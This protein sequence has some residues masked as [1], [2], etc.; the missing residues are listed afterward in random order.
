[1]N[2]KELRNSSSFAHGRMD[3]LETRINY[4]FANPLL[5]A[6][7]LTHPS[8]AYETQGPHFD[9]Q[10]LEFLGDA[11]L[12]LI[13]TRELFLAFPA[14]DEGTLTKLRSQLVSRAALVRYAQ[15]IDLGAY[16]LIG[17]GEAASGGRERASTLSDALEALIGAVYLD[18]DLPAATT[19][20]LEL[21]GSELKG[22]NSNTDSLNPKGQLQ[23]ILQSL[24]G[25]NPTYELVDESGPDHRKEFISRVLW[26]G[27][28][29][30]VGRGSSKKQAEISA[31]QQA[32]VHPLVGPL[33]ETTPAGGGGGPTESLR[34]A[35]LVVKPL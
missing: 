18:G 8:L 33:S 22:L 9:N 16:L 5:L 27:K 4:H 19:V 20:V 14:M 25:A 3:S 35:P 17:K 15:R 32:L 12:Q 30:G 31:A 26:Q 6:E 34:P 11:V 21:S 29:L 2:I 1:L 10:R 7:A 28:L 23:E 13:L 24:G